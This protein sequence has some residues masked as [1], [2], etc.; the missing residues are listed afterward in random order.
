MCILCSFQLLFPA[1]PEDVNFTM[2]TIC[3][4]RGPVIAHY[5]TQA[6]D[7]KKLDTLTGAVRFSL[8]WEVESKPRSI[9]RGQ[10]T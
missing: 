10:I 9:I 3:S 7:I 4:S 6:A 2:F 8:L 5:K 1:F